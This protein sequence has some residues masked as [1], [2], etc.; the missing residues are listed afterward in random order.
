MTVL[1]AIAELNL[2]VQGGYRERFP[3]CCYL[4][5][6]KQAPFPDMSR[7]KACM[8]SLAYVNLSLSESIVT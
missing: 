4:K 6:A 5:V 1:N 7:E 8:L 2:Y 3:E